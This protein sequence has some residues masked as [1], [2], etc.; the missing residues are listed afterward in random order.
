MEIRVRVRLLCFA[1]LIVVLAVLTG[2]SERHRIQVESDVCWDAIINDEQHVAECGNVSYKVTGKIKCI[3][4]QKQSAA[5]YLRVRID[6][7]PWTETTEAFGTVQ[8]CY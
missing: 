2:C 3:V 6:S 8:A 7:R 5:G 1:A 4:A